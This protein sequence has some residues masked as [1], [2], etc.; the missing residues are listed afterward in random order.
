MLI[1]TSFSGLS[2]SFLTSGF[3]PWTDPGKFIN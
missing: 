3:D 1:D 2:M